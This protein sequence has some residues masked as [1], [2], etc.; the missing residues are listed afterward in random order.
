LS[1]PSAVPRPLLTLLALAALAAA[2]T[3]TTTARAQSG[4]AVKVAGKS[5]TFTLAPAVKQRIDRL[6]I[7]LA[8]VAPATSSGAA[9]ATFPITSVR[10]KVQRLRGVVRHSGGLT[11]TRGDRKVTLRNIAIVANG[12]RGFAT[13]KLGQRRIR[14]FRLTGAK[15]SVEGTKVTLSV[16]LRL[17]AQG[18]RFVNRRLPAARLQ[19]GRVLGSAVLSG[20]L[21][22][23]DEQYADPFA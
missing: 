14:V 15:R 6:G 22:P 1:R 5:T 21:V 11:L 3:A 16:T 18:A 8:V 20:T 13:A 12:K 10:G 23:A 4:A 19:A 9:T 17:T 7:K 2:L